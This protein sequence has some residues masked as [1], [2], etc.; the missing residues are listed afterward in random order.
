MPTVCW[1]TRP[2]NIANISSMITLSMM[3]PVSECSSFFFFYKIRFVSTLTIFMKQSWTYYSNL[4]LSLEWGIVMQRRKKLS[5]MVL[6]PNCNPRYGGGYRIHY[7]RSPGG[8]T[9]DS[10]QVPVFS[11]ISGYS[12]WNRLILVKKR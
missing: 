2:P 9:L 4:S 7:Y 8:S 11:V 12:P 6:L 10:I 5:K 3:M 1:K